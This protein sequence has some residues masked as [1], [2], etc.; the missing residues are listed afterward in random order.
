MKAPIKGLT[1]TLLNDHKF[2]TS[3]IMGTKKNNYFLTIS[4]RETET[5]SFIQIWYGKDCSTKR[6]EWT[7]INK[8][9]KQLDSDIKKFGLLVT[10]IEN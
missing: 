2:N 5:D 6:F 4:S 7:N 9:F 1:K 8:L 10:E 3:I